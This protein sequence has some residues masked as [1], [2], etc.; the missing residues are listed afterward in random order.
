MISLLLH[1]RLNWSHNYLRSE[2][3]GCKRVEWRV[4]QFARRRGSN[5]LCPQVGYL[6]EVML[7]ACEEIQFC[8]WEFLQPKWIWRGAAVWQRTAADFESNELVSWKKGNRLKEME[9]KNN[10][11][12]FLMDSLREAL[13]GPSQQAADRTRQ[14][15]DSS[16]SAV[17]WLIPYSVHAS[18][19]CALLCSGLLVLWW[20]V[21]SLSLL[22]LCKGN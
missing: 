17:L 9:T 15:A 10:M 13:L 8:S 16:S 7:I 22:P 5:S 11:N 6:M 1:K 14:L 2:S 3:L 4:L 21:V 20:S 18:K 19:T 12:C